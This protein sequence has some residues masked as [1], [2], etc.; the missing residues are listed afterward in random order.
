MKKAIIVLLSCITACML[1]EVEASPEPG[2]SAGMQDCGSWREPVLCQSELQTYGSD[3]RWQRFDPTRRLQLAPRVSFELEIRGRD[4][5]GRTFPQSRISLAFDNRECSRLLQVEDLG[6]GRLRID[7]SSDSG[8]CRLE[9]WVPGNLNHAWRLDVEVTASAR[10]GYSSAEAAM[11]VNALYRGLL[12]RDPD[13]ASLGAA[14]SEVQR[15]NLQ[16]QVAAMTRSSEFQAARGGLD[17]TA[18]LDRIYQGVFG[19]P[20][21]ASGSRDY[22][23]RIQIGQYDD[24][25]LSLLRSPEFERRLAGAR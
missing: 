25:I 18:I 22:L 23:Q 2:S 19:R 3:R 13:S 12:N 16:S 15:G 1:P 5:M 21:D 7:A 24:V 9:I 4:Q 10:S 8:S 17:P 20:L 11:I 6:E 14:I